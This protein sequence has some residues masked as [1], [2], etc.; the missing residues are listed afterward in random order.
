MSDRLGSFRR[1]SIYFEGLKRLL[2]RSGSLKAIGS[3]S[4]LCLGSVCQSEWIVPAEEAGRKP[5]FDANG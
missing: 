3:V 4:C 5:R 2:F 1:F